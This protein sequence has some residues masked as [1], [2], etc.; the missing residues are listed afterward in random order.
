MFDQVA[1]VLISALQSVI[2][3]PATGG[4]LLQ[5]CPLDVLL[6]LFLVHPD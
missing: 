6:P 5:I 4:N 3:S 1:H 2:P